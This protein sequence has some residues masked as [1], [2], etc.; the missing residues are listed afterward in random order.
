LFLFQYFEF[1]VVVK[2]GKYNVGLYHLSWIKTG[3][4]SQSLDDELLDAKLFRLK[5]I[6]DQLVDITEF[7]MAGKPLPRYT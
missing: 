1:E 5:S 6:L 7:L 3:E 2:P 4:A